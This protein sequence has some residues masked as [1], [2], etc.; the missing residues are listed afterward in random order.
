MSDTLTLVR[1]VVRSHKAQQAGNV[2]EIHFDFH[3]AEPRAYD[4]PG[5]PAEAEV[6]Q[7]TV[8]GNDITDRLDA[9][10]LKALEEVI[11]AARKK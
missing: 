2:M 8:N 9:A 3:A 6:L 7:V 1:H 11:V 10:A 4:Y 5:Y